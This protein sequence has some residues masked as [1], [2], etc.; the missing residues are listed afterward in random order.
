M[1]L[2][3][4]YDCPSASEV[5]LKDHRITYAKN[6][7]YKLSLE[8]SGVFHESAEANDTLQCYNPNEARPNRV[9]I[10]SDS[11]DVYISMA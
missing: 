4:S 11:W 2:G 3:Q 10:L 6:D 9:H 8:Q 1:A 7:W 5:T